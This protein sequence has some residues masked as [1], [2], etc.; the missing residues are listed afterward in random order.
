MSHSVVYDITNTYPSE[1][2]SKFY[3]FK[4]D[5]DTFNTM[6]SIA[7]SENCIDMEE[8]PYNYE[9]QVQIDKDEAQRILLHIYKLLIRE[10]LIPE[11][12]CMDFYNKA[13][14]KL[15]FHA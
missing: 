15:Y 2:G 9:T 12:K 1:S 3:S 10:N 6:I 4:L 8:Y 13:E 11:N 5:D 7:D 14:L